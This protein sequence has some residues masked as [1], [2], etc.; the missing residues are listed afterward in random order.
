MSNA[1]G[2]FP[3]LWGPGQCAVNTGCC[4]FP[5]RPRLR[6][7]P[8][9]RSGPDRVRGEHTTPTG[10]ALLKVLARPLPAEATFV[11]EQVGYGAGAREEGPLPNVL[12]GWLAE[13]SAPDAGFLWELQVQ[14]DDLTGE[15]AGFVLERLLAAGAIDAWIVQIL[16]KKGRPGLLVC[17]LTDE[18][19]RPAVEEVLLQETQTLGIRRLRVER[20]RLPRRVHCLESS[21]GPVRCKVRTLAQGREE[22][23][24]EQ[25]D[26]ARLARELGL[27]LGT[28]L[29]RLQRELPAD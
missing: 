24:V 22:W 11:P 12:R 8:G 18:G 25:E 13:V 15:A 5:L 1:S 2:P 26:A 29:A 16:M 6:F 10:A 27:P 3:W 23:S 7:W 19:L 4:R 9:S 17:A 14:L 20:T 28:V 21:L